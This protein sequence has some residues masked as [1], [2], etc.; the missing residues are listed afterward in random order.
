MSAK[1]FKFVSPGVFLSEIDQSQLPKTPGAIGPVVIGRT[2]R[3]PALKPVKVN[4]FQEFVEIF[5]DPIPGNEG[6]DPWRDGN[7]LL[8]TAYAPLA[9]QAYL[10]AEIDSPVTVIR[11]LGAQGDDASDNGQPGWDVDHAF[12]LFVAPSSSAAAITGSLVGI[13]YA[14]Q[15]GFQFGVKGTEHNGTDTITSRALGSAVDFGNVKAVKRR[16]YPSEMA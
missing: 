6:E 10:K 13:V 4:S 7:G 12:G 11:L 15:N 2:R 3:G 8:A 14:A 5:G 16:R 1:K 9:A